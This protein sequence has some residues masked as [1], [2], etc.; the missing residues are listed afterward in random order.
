MADPDRGQWIYVT[1]DS[2]QWLRVNLPSGLIAP[3]VITLHQPLEGPVKFFCADAY[4]LPIPEA[5]K[6]AGEDGDGGS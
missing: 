3:P 4:Q 5:A 6:V 2:S 1:A